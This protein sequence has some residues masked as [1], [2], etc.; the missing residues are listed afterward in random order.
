MLFDGNKLEISHE[1]GFSINFNAVDAL[2]GV[3]NKHDLMKVAI[4]NEWQ[5]LRLVF[6]FLLLIIFRM[7]TL[8][9]L[10]FQ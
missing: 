9:Y 5:K 3:D 4:A 10:K 8:I 2:R 1:N 6:G 7:I